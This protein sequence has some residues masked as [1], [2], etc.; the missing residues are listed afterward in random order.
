MGN[1]CSKESV[2]PPPV[3][4]L[5]RLRSRF[6]TLACDISTCYDIGN[7]IGHGHFGT[8]RLS[9]PKKNPSLKLAIKSIDK[10]R[11]KN[12]SQMRQEVEILANLD[13]PN[14]VKLYEN[15][16]NSRFYHLV[17]EYCSGGELME[18]LQKI[19]HY[20]ENEAVGIMKNILSTINHLHASN[21][22]HR[23][24]KCE[25][26]MFESHEPDAELKL[27]DFGL[28]HKFGNLDKN[29]KSLVGTPLYVAPEV[30]KGI[31]GP[32]CD[33]W[34]IGV[35]MYLLLSGQFPFNG[36]NRVQIFQKISEADLNLQSGIWDEISESAKDLLIRLLQVD[37]KKR[38]YTEDALQHSWFKHIK[39]NEIVELN[40]KI[41]DCF[42]NFKVSSC[43]QKEALTIIVRDMENAELKNLK[44]AFL[45]MDKSK[46]GYLTIKDLTDAMICKDNYVFGEELE[47]YFKNADLNGDGKINYSEFLIATLN[48]EYILDEGRL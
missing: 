30:L 24:I 20:P 8:V 35:I 1:L 3:I 33:I 4:P 6:P 25:N 12:F 41:I 39:T 16:E 31:Y 13:H 26:F 38:I 46:V 2:P 42:R 15:Y 10:T 5:R 23:D 32:E 47:N 44:D 27:I 40:P 43:F 17:M 9:N 45:S 7:I 37:P 11:I 22:C 29:M 48:S 34:S 14:I 18:R 28:S 36:V 19:G 21:I